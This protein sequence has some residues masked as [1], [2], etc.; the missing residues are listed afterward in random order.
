MK[1]LV[2]ITLLLLIT[3][4]MHAMQME[5]A[6]NTSQK[7]SEHRAELKQADEAGSCLD[8]CCNALKTCFYVGAAY[9]VM[10]CAQVTQEPTVNNNSHG[11]WLVITG[12]GNCDCSGGVLFASSNRCF[13]KGACRENFVDS[14]KEERDECKDRYLYSE[15]ASDRQELHR[16]LTMQTM[17]N[18]P[19][20]A[21]LA[22]KEISERE[23]KRAHCRKVAYLQTYDEYDHI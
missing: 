1:K 20:Y 22:V 4:R 17:L 10:R 7:K 5:T 16:I 2:C 19:E 3:D 18:D 6:G 23:E 14:D 8:M 12:Q 11:P 21:Q 13:L 15:T 9:Y